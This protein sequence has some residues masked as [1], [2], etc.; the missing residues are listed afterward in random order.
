MTRPARASFGA[1]WIAMV[2]AV[3]FVSARQPSAHAPPQPIDLAT[4]LPVDP[5]VA[6][7]QLA[8]GLRYY[9]RA[10]HTPAKRAELRL[11]V[12]A[13]SILEDDNQRGLAH[14]VEHMAFDGTAHFPG[15]DVVNFMQALGMQFGAHVNAHTS[16]DE[17]VYQ[18]TIP[19]DQSA[20]LD[21]AL[22]IL[23]D[24]AHDVTFDPDQVERERK[25]VMEEWRLGRGADARLMD[26]QFPVLLSGSHYADRVPIGLPSVIQGATRENIKRFYDDWYRPDL[27][28][29]VAV[30]DFDRGDVETLVRDHFSKI[31]TPTSPRSRPVF[32]VPAHPGTRYSIETDKEATGTDVT[33]FALAP[34]P[35]ESTLGA[36]RQQQVL[37]PLFASLLSNR[38]SESARQPD[39]P[40]LAAQTQRSRLVRTAAATTLSAIV[41]DGGVAKGLEALM[42]ETARLARFGFT[43]TELRRAKDRLLRSVDQ[44]LVE[45]EN[46]PSSRLAEEFTRSFTTGEPIPGIAYEARLYHRF[47]PEVTLADMNAMALDWV[48]DQNRIVLVSAPDKPGAT[49]PTE[50]ELAAAVTNAEHQPLQPYVDAVAA[51]PL[52]DRMPAPGA[53]ARTATNDRLGLI[54][55]RLSNGARVVL[56]PTPFKEDEILVRAFAAGGY[57]LASDR[58]FTA[59]ETAAE[60]VS[61]GG[62]GQLSAI[63]LQKKLAGTMAHVMPFVE[64]TEQGLNGGSSRQDLETLLQLIYLRFTEPRADPGAFRVIT[65]QVRSM[66]ADRTAPDFAFEETLQSTL[67]QNHPRGRPLTAARINEMSLETS[68][69]FY[70]QRF[71][72]ASGFTFVFVGS[73][74]PA[75]LKPLVERYIA[76]LPA[77]RRVETWRDD[78]VRYPTS[79]VTKRIEQGVEPKSQVAVVFTG[80]FQYDAT[81]RVALH[82]LSMILD[83]HLLHSLRE[84]LGGTYGVSVRETTDR[85]PVPRY[86]LSIAFTCNPTR[87]DELVKEVFDQIALLKT[88][89]PGEAEVRD[90]ALA[91]QRETETN[92]RDNAYLLNAIA[93]RYRD[94]EIVDSLLDL[95]GLYA[96]LSARQVWDAARTYLDTTRYV[97]VTLFPE[98][99]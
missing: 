38:L 99:K 33:L 32:T 65:A 74:D 6:V 68:M 95:R 88:R 66:L 69:A 49:V 80:P 30:G 90:V 5:Q 59:A 43:D 48:P 28:A 21:R 87:T 1:A 57:S 94:G 58:D 47:V 85:I 22:L 82:A 8:N 45:T 97:Q 2:A 20:V 83:G 62:V 46:E 61:A 51:A 72:G 98:K 76:G 79:V 27:M 71:A 18:L 73:I 70:R 42:V 55:W 40:F 9:I 11:V 4:T 54:E 19:T 13:G 29:V 15:H 92:F 96:G 63:D 56:R 36:Y 60:V 77:M 53:I 34:A 67:T 16:F 86:A 39:A 78:G 17:T 24:W 26:K 81:H 25:V 93:Q 23:E 84:D 64:R 12:N 10:H 44:A 91:L 41:V 7:G 31:P 75:T 3:A 35:D 89:G 52:L 50:F 14:L 37:E